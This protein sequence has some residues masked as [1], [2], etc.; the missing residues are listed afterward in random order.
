MNVDVLHKAVPSS[1]HLLDYIKVYNEN[2]RIPDKLNE[3]NKKKLNSFLK[4][5]TIGYRLNPID[6]LK[7]YSFNGV[8]DSASKATFECNEK[9]ITVK[10]YFEKERKIKLK[11]PN[12]PVL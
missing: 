1:V 10:D 8:K 6:P 7:T 2:K 5:L 4:M 3:E 12:L 9:S 11:F